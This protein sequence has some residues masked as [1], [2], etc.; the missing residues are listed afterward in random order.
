MVRALGPDDTATA[1]GSS[2]TDTATATATGDGGGSGSDAEIIEEDIP[3]DD[4]LGDDDAVRGRAFFF[5]L[6]LYCWFCFVLFARLSMLNH[7]WAKLTYIY[8]FMYAHSTA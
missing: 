8:A 7:S 6:P 2:A 3:T 4:E 1:L 5:F